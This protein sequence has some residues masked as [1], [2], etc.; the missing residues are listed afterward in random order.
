MAI[1]ALASARVRDGALYSNRWTPKALAQPS[2]DAFFTAA[3]N[4]LPKGDISA[5]REL[6]YLRA[7]CFLTLTALQNRAI[8][9]MHYYL[10]FYGMFV[11]CCMLHDEKYWT[12][13]MPVIEKEERRRLV[14]WM[15]FAAVWSCAKLII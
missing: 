13:P 2:S 6:D 1:C 9:K 14:S 5:A 4:A 10:G 8:P 15:P 3:E 11:K 12:T 7:C